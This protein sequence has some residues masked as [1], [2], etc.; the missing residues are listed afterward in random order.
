MN[1]SLTGAVKCIK[2]GL[3]TTQ[4]SMKDLNTMDCYLAFKKKECYNKDELG[5]H[6]AE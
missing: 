6:Y 5:G 4:V 2:M 3:Y 1:Q